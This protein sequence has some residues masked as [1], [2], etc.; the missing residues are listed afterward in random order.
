MA[1]HGTFLIDGMG[2]IRWLDIS[3][4]PFTETEFLLKESQRLLSQPQGIV[5][6]KK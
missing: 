4:D 3:Y 5:Y 1:L 6:G 2:Y